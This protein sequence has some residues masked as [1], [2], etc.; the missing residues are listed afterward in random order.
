MKKSYQNYF[1]ALLVCMLIIACLAEVN[2]VSA[3]LQSALGASTQYHTSSSPAVAPL[4]MKHTVRMSK[5]PVATAH[6]V[7]PPNSDSL[8]END[9]S[10][11]VLQLKASAAHAP[12]A[13]VAPFVYHYHPGNRGTS[14]LEVPQQVGNN[15]STP[16]L[17]TSFQGMALSN[18]IC[19]LTGCVAPDMALAV[20]P[21]WVFQGVNTSFAV[22]DT[23]GKLQQGWP[24][25]AQSFFGV[26]SPPGGCAGSVPYLIDPRAFYDPKDGR[27][28]AVILQDAGTLGHQTSCPYVDYL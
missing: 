28:W 5:V 15:S 11:T 13:P 9:E 18:T 7:T 1:F 23:S 19:P 4:V 12:N 27:F 3:H 10:D 14:G 25:N 6:S 21:N 8:V 20:S 16:G 22:Y 24:K 26:P 2:W 17:T